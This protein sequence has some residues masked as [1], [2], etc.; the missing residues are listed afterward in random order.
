MQVFKISGS[1]S[2]DCKVAEAERQVQSAEVSISSAVR[3]ALRRV[4]QRNGSKPGVA[5]SYCRVA[6]TLG[7][8]WVAHQ[9]ADGRSVLRPVVVCPSVSC[10]V[11]SLVVM[12]LVVCTEQEALNKCRNWNNAGIYL[13][14]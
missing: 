11:Y 13:S 10:T 5:Y 12:E 14:M 3:N 4:D 2:A 7:D 6:V 9:A 1:S 8:T